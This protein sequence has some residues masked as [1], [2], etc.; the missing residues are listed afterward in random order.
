MSRRETLIRATPLALATTAVAGVLLALRR[1]MTRAR[2]PANGRYTL[3]GLRAPVEI[4]RDRWGVPHVYARSQ[5]DLFFAQGFVHAQDRLFQMEVNRRVGLGRVSELI[6]PLGI[7]TDRFARFMGWPRAAQAQIDGSDTA[8]QRMGASY[9]AGVNAFIQSRPLPPEYALLAV[10]PE[11]WT[12]LHTAAWGSVLAWGLSVNWETELQRLLLLQLFGAEKTADLTPHYRD[13]YTTILPDTQVGA[14]F[15]AAL[16][17][18]YRD[19]LATMPLGSVPSGGSNNWV[20]DGRL[21]ASGR[22]V[23]A[24]DPHLTPIFP[25]FWYE[26]HLVCDTFEVS[27]FTMPGVPGIVIGHNAHVAWGLT[28]AFP[29]VQDLYVER[30]DSQDA[31]RYEIDGRWHTAETVV[32]TIRVRGRKPLQETVRYTVHGPVISDFLPHGEAALA[33]QWIAYSPSNHLR[34]VLDSLHARDA[35]EL[36]NAL[37]HWGFA[38]QNV[39]YADV[40]GAI[41]YCMPGRVP[42]RRR[43]H[44][45]APVPGWDSRYGWDD[46]LPFDELPH[47]VNPA[48]GLIVTANNRVHGRDYPH[49]LTGEWLPDS[50]ATRIRTMLLARAPLTLADHAAVQLDTTSLFMARFVAQAL[51]A[52]DGVPLSDELRV[53]RTLL[54]D[55]DGDMR[56]EAVA[57]TLAYGWLVRFSYAVLD[58]AVGRDVREQ[59]L[60]RHHDVD[61]SLYPFHEAA[62]E[63]VLD[64]LETAP[65]DWIGTIRPLLRPALEEALAI[66]RQQVG[67]D[68]HNWG[69]G[70][71]HYV[72]FNHFAARVPALGRLWKPRR[73]PLGGDGYTPS[74]ADITLH[75]PPDP[76]HVIASCRLIMDVGAWDNCVAAL[77]GGQSAVP[78]SPHYQDA[79]EEWLH[80]RYHPM[81][82][83]REQ[84]MAAA[85]GTHWLLPAG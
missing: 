81:L 11:P 2:L 45:L 52:L 50:R 13:D 6:G 44:G 82:F 10:H 40:D 16:I 71:L 69:W 65:P 25:A 21:T 80:G 62:G 42:R 1:V 78:T 67:R 72:K 85:N 35:T 51:P 54:A 63:L 28:N 75:F 41:G 23:V 53:V 77:P 20:V 32:E 74:Q 31:T 4:I 76:V 43:G 61:F 47:Y 15:A 5:D 84:V 73:E 22:P 38:S 24:N 70:A 26:N 46:W 7:E 29:D 83:S 30:F 8:V 59:L 9:S 66:L 37:R 14:R 27:G 57:P 60:P 17:E 18:A 49:L 64:W 58:T 39:V 55:W 56:R 34:T 33:L 68:M 36:R 12:M 3:D 19:V 79:L 48:E